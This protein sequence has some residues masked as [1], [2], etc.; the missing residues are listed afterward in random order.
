MSSSPGKMFWH[1]AEPW[2][3]KTSAT[4]KYFLVSEKLGEYNSS[5]S[6]VSI[7]FTRL[8]YFCNFFQ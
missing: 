2:G 4:Y 5:E 8:Y 6:P 7:M 3:P 1:R